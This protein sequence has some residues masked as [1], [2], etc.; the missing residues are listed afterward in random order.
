[1]PKEMTHISIARK[2][3]DHLSEDSLFLGPIQKHFNLFLYGSIAPD[4]CYYYLLGPHAL[5]IQNQSK[6]FH[7]T[8]S[9]SLVP[10]IDFL[11]H[12]PDKNPKALAFAAGICCHIIT[13]TLFHPM[14][15][16][17]SGIEGLHPGARTRH[18]LMETALDIFFWYQNR[19][20]T[21]LFHDCVF[22]D[23][24]RSETELIC[25]LECLFSLEKR[26]WQ[27]H[28]KRAFKSHHFSYN[29]FKNHTVYKII[30]LFHRFK[31][32]IPSRFETLFYPVSKPVE[33]LFFNDLLHY[34]DPIKGTPIT[35]KI[36]Q[37]TQ[38]TIQQVLSLLFI[39]QATR[40]Q[41]QVLTDIMDHPDLPLIRP[42]LLKENFKYWYGQ[43]DLQPVIYKDL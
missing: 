14:V 2:V 12:F 27:T 9:S 36:E 39:F 19:S 38:K 40:L 1:M 43:K 30:K 6:K 37:L 8:D 28:L 29:L 13:D 34:H 25:F 35:H 20:D 15:Y 4:T 31:L 23:L 18:R 5:F 41:G 21:P 11:K 3:F 32:G 16:Y 17:F 42:C 7:T 22:S 10:V 33:L 26:K 24:N